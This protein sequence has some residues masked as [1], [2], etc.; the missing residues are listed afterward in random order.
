MFHR[1]SKMYVF[2]SE[3]SATQVLSGLSKITSGCAYSKWYALWWLSCLHLENLWRV[4]VAYQRYFYPFF[5]NFWRY[6]KPY[7]QLLSK[8]RYKIQLTFQKR[9]PFNQC[10][11]GRI[12]TFEHSA[13]HNYFHDSKPCSMFSRGDCI[14]RIVNLK[15]KKLSG[16]CQISYRRFEAVSMKYEL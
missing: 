8:S 6:Q 4:T 3:S 14:I 15:K 11:T 9:T 1:L 7:I 12:A 10:Q 5:W 16:Q 2:G 13:I